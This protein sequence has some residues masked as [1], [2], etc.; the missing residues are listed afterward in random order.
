MF[1]FSFNSL[2]ILSISVF[3]SFKY[4]N[5]SFKC[6]K[7]GFFITKTIV[8]INEIEIKLIKK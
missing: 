4:V 5:K 3:K 7:T 8:L 1:L 2:L 6:S